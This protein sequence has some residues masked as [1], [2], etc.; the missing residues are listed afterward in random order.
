MLGRFLRKFVGTRASAPEAYGW[1]RAARKAKRTK[2]QKKD[3]FAAWLKENPEGTFDQ[4]YVE[5]VV[6]ALAGKKNHASLGPT[7][8]EH[9]R[10]DRAQSVV[11]RWLSRGIQPSDTV[12]DYGCGTLRLGRILIEFLDPDRYIGLDIDHRILAAG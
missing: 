6:E 11:E 8:K 9:Q 3:K 4:F 10:P 1:N 12:V 7:L 5:S 2:K